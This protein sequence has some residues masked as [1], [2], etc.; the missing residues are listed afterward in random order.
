LTQT[1]SR[2]KAA[3][4]IVVKVGTTT[5]TYPTGKLNLMIVEKLVRVLSDLK[6][7]GKNVILVTS[8]AIGVGRAKIGYMKRPD[9][10]PEKQA[11]AAIG[12]VNL[13]YTYSKLFGEYGHLTSQVLLT[14]DVLDGG[15]REHNAV[16]TFQNLFKFNSIPIV[17]END[18]IS[19]E[20]IQFGDNDTLSAIVAVLVKADLLILL[21]DI[22]GL[23]DKDPNGHTDAELIH[24]VCGI[25]EEILKASG[26]S[27]SDL[28]TG[29]MK[30]KVAAAQI[31]HQ[32]DIPMV[33]ANGD[34]PYNINRVLAG[35]E[36]GTLFVP[37]R[38]GVINE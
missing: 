6:N 22:D 27:H 4:T 38:E 11:L 20:Q 23:Y 1:R 3:E 7:Q 34:D 12:Q 31:C 26:S 28:G 30:T 16:N 24:V 17:N 10:I 9:S 32:H 29:G 19:I 5:I 8:G 2:I 21:S 25:T 35:E 33:I 15:E 18:T 14:K 37:C 36:V 13:M